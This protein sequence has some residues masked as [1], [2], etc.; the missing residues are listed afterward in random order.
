MQA[1]QR[2]DA[3]VVTDCPQRAIAADVGCSWLA[4]GGGG[5]VTGPGE[6][7][8]GMALVWSILYVFAYLPPARKAVS[9]IKVIS[10]QET[11]ELDLHMSLNGMEVYTTWDVSD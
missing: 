10:Q 2:K 7:K 1:A 4:G 8:I 9:K 6:K 3:G 5:D 11:P